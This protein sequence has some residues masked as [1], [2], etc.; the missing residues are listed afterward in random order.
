VPS[1]GDLARYI[2]DNSGGGHP[3]RQVTDLAC[4]RCR[5]TAFGVAVD[6]DDNCAVATCVNCR[7]DIAIADTR[8]RLRDAEPGECDCICGGETFGVAVGYAVSGTDA[9][10]VTIGL[11]C[12]TDDVL[13]VIGDWEITERPSA[14]LLSS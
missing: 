6:D 10:W 7:T 13:G 11:R 8:R 1:D 2:H 12:L 5:G 14:H 4:G 9:T 3:V